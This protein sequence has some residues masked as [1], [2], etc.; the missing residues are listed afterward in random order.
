MADSTDSQHPSVELVL[1]TPASS[2]PSSNP[3]D[4]VTSTFPSPKTSSPNATLDV[5]VS[6]PADMGLT[7]TVSPPVTKEGPDFSAENMCE[8]T[9]TEPTDDTSNIIQSE[10]EIIEGFITTLGTREK[11]GGGGSSSAEECR[12]GLSRD[13]PFVH[14]SGEPSSQETPMIDASP[15]WDGT[16]PRKGV[17]DLAP[18]EALPTDEGV[19]S[20]PA[21][22]EVPLQMV[23]KRK[24]RTATRP[25]AQSSLATSGGPTTRG[26]VKKS[27]DEILE[28]SRQTTLKRRRITRRT[29]LE[30]EPLSSPVVD[31]ECG[32]SSHSKDESSKSEKP[33]GVGEGV[34][35]PA[36][37]PGAPVIRSKRKHILAKSCRGKRPVAATVG[38]DDRGGA[39]G[40]STVSNLIEAQRRGTEEIERLTAAQLD[41]LTRQMICDQRAAND[42]I[43]KLLAKI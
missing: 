18:P 39:G 7:G 33:V 22:D 30:D 15:K 4:V 21:E 23:F 40:Q 2:N 26:T 6:L 1:A 12:P 14:S 28:R 8:G 16:P 9:L 3:R 31:L 34:G 25:V 20:P 43:D 37:E 32:T 29:V 35:K 5:S 10:A 38:E 41:E 36:E 24:S 11:D 13:C 42:R 17:E 27:L 19:S